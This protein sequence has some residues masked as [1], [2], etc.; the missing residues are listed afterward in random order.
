MQ[1]TSGGRSHFSLNFW[2]S[3]DPEVTVNQ[4]SAELYSFEIFCK[5]FFCF[6]LT[7]SLHPEH[8]I[9][10]KS[11][12]VLHLITC[13]G[14]I[15][16]RLRSSCFSIKTYVVALWNHAYSNILKILQ[17]NDE[18]FQIKNSDIFHISAQNIDCGYS[19]ESPWL[20]GCNEYPQSMVFN[21]IRKIMLPL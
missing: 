19:F 6:Q 4:R 8:W 18:N 15:M 13:H 12:Y 21:K 7:Y 20:G 1:Q 10:Q 3:L 17:P 5:F 2:A 9:I 16:P 11:V 14:R